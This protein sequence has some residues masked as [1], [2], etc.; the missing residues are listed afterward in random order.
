MGPIGVKEHLIPF[1]PTTNLDKFTD[2]NSNGKVDTSIGAISAAPWGSA[3]ILVISW[4]YIAMMGEKGLTEA[5]KVAILNANYMAS[6]LADYYPIL[7]KGASGCVAHE[8]I[9]DLRPLKNQAEVGVD[10][11]A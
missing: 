1:L 10:D 7:F 9:I 11:I 5:T 6:R 2:P 8:C 4:M 3:S